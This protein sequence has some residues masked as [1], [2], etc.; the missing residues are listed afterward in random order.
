MLLI[1]DIVRKSQPTV[2]WSMRGLPKSQREAIYT[3]FA[4]CRHIDGLRNSSLLPDEKLKLLRVWREEFDN[5]Y[6]KNTPATDIGKKIYKNCLRFNL[7][8]E[9]LEKILDSAFLDVPTPVFAPKIE[10]FRQYI[11]G[12]A[13]VPFY[14]SFKIIGCGNDYILHKLAENL[15]YAISITYM[16]RNVKKDCC[17]GRVFI[18]QEL[19]QQA[20]INSKN[21]RSVLEDKNLGIAR[22]FMAL[23]AQK[24]FHQ[25]DKILEKMEHS[26]VMPFI[27]IKNIC[28]YHL[29]LMG[30]R[31]WNNVS[32]NIR[33]SL[34][35]Y[36]KIVVETLF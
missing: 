20:N 28:E 26:K 8:R 1:G 19:L 10:D 36:L 7:P 18:P 25:A 9:L 29:E 35:K 34:Y 11:D 17:S 21:A 16:L 31:G 14:I 22:E 24:S 4:F 5:I 6:D 12:S 32:A 23:E 3:V 30:K 2:F 33:T 15:G 27:F 13:I